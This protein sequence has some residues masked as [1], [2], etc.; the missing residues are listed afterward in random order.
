MEMA[1]VRG[2]LIA[3]ALV[4]LPVARGGE[5]RRVVLAGRVAAIESGRPIAGA[6]VVVTRSY[7]GAE[8]AA[9]RAWAGVDSLRT[10]DAGRF[11]VRLPE[12]DMTDARFLLEVR[13]RHP[14]RVVRRSYG[15]TL[16]DVA[17]EQSRGGPSFCDPIELEVGV[18]YTATVVTPEDT[19][20]AGVPFHATVAASSSSAAGFYND[21]EG[22]TDA[23]GRLR[24][25]LPA[26]QEMNLSIIP[27]AFAP[28][29]DTRGVEDAEEH[30]ERRL[31]AHLGRYILDPG[32]TILGGLVGRDG[33]P[34]AGVRIR[35]WGRQKNVSRESITDGDGRF[36]LRALPSDVY[37]I[38]AADQTREGSIDLAARPAAPPARVVLPQLIQLWPGD[39]EARIELR[40]AETV[41]VAARYLDAKGCPVRGGPMM[42]SGFLR[43]D[44][45]VGDGVQAAEQPDR[46]VGFFVDIPANNGA[47]Q[48]P[49][50]IQVSPGPD[51]RVALRV[52]KGLNDASLTASAADGTTALRHGDKPGEPLVAGGVV[53]LGT[54]DADRDRIEFRA[55]RSPAIRVTVRAEDGRPLPDDLSVVPGF[56]DP[57]DDNQSDAR[58]EE[59]RA[60]E[61]R[62]VGFLPDRRYEVVAT[63]SGYTPGRSEQFS[64]PEGR[65]LDLTLTLSPLPRPA[66]AGDPAPPFCVRTLDGRMRT[67]ADYRGKY[68]LVAV[69]SHEGNTATDVEVLK[70]LREAYRKDPRFAMLGLSGDF[71][72]KRLADF[73]RESKMSW[74]HARLGPLLDPL[75]AAYGWE[76]LPCATLIGPDGTI[77]A[78]G[79]RE[80]ALGAAVEEHL[81]PKGR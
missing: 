4:A 26:T 15:R 8:D 35:A 70:A 36:R 16:K 46:M 17:E 73:L 47:R 23:R 69:W 31:P 19:P 51:G 20:A 7:T 32:G 80:N 18:E 30:P 49:W 58:F 56:S 24:V 14:D 22:M 63:A 48:V 41:T 10:D 43:D 21:G 55:Y 68:L 12:A 64:L 62:G 79:L 25:R 52:P 44:A 40:E 45:F 34:V 11:R 67:L 5:P 81:D 71:D 76:P 74:P 57:E 2:L 75:T 72:E 28:F 3:A 50:G 42:I 59:V 65:A 29:H 78:T 61:F 6:E 13:A 9:A 39:R 66:Q 1:A 38:Q 54:L 37:A 33:R 77:L 60:G 27:E 53:A